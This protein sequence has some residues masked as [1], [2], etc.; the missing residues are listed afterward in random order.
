MPPYSTTVN[1]QPLLERR[2]VAA[3]STKG[4]VRIILLEIESLR[5]TKNLAFL[6]MI[7]QNTDTPIALM[8]IAT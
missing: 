7:V 3:A 2:S 4:E 8:W 6:S 5:K 1:M